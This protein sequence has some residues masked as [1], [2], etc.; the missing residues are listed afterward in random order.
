LRVAQAPLGA[1]LKQ[2]VGE[3]DLLD[4]EQRRRLQLVT[5]D[6]GEER[7]GLLAIEERLDGLAGVRAAGR[8]R[9]ASRKFLPDFLPILTSPDVTATTERG[10]RTGLG[11]R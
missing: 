5:L 2:N 8:R 10:L 4:P 1:L 7:L 3:L 11:N 6:L 9:R